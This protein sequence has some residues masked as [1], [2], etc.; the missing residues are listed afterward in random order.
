MVYIGSVAPK[1]GGVQLLY[2]KP[3]VT[4]QGRVYVKHSLIKLINALSMFKY[5][6]YKVPG[7]LCLH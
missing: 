2:D 7:Q 4:L 1:A 3:M 5:I 6:I